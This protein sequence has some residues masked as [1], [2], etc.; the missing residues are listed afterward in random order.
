MA[1]GTAIGDKSV[2]L[3]LDT[4][5][6]ACQLPDEAQ[7]MSGTTRITG[8]PTSIAEVL[9]NRLWERP[10][11]TMMDGELYDALDAARRAASQPAALSLSPQ[12]QAQLANAA[13]AV[14]AVATEKS[15]INERPEPR[16]DVPAHAVQ[17]LGH[18]DVQA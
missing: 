3:S 9:A 10:R 6:N 2:H 8:T 16:P 15:T 17:P 7:A 5:K 11:R 4:L 12:A 13:G 1:S 18:V 14:A